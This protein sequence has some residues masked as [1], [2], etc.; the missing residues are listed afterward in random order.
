MPAQALTVEKPRR[1]AMSKR[2]NVVE[3]GDVFLVPLLD[4]R[5]SVGQVLDFMMPNAPSCAIYGQT[6]P[7]PPERPIEILRNDVICSVSTTRDLLDSG[8]WKVVAN[9]SV[10]LERARWPNEQF[11]SRNWVGAVTQGSGI[12]ENFLNA[13]HGLAPWDRYKDP[14]YFDEMLISEAIKPQVLVFKSH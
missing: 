1:L 10:Q 8:R 5:Y 7:F 2:H 4:G 14:N 9:R 12:V 11:R 13:F 6:T 3:A